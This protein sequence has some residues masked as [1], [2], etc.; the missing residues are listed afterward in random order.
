MTEI[1]SL[2]LSVTDQVI[3]L[4]IQYY[5]NQSIYKIGKLIYAHDTCFSSSLD[6]HLIKSEKKCFIFQTY[7]HFLSVFLLL[8]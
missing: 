2:L 1:K 4:R 6:Q 5:R 7:F 3:G 8:Q